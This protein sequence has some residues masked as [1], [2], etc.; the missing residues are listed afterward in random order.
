M[1][2]SVSARLVEDYL[3]KW[4]FTSGCDMFCPLQY[5]AKDYA[6]NIWKGYG[7]CSVISLRGAVVGFVEEPLSF[8][9]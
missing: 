3:Q 4:A 7:G 1:H 9:V 2:Y 8:V 6:G 5:L